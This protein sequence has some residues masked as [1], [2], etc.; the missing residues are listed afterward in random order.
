MDKK[1]KSWEW[2]ESNF[3]L[4]KWKCTV[5]CWKKKNLWRNNV[6]RNQVSLCSYY[7]YR[8]GGGGGGHHLKWNS[9]SSPRNFF[10]LLAPLWVECSHCVKRSCGFHETHACLPPHSFS[11]KLSA[12]PSSPEICVSHWFLTINL[13]VMCALNCLSRQVL[14]LGCVDSLCWR[15][16]CFLG[17]TWNIIFFFKFDNIL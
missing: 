13:A 16:C 11:M 6:I 7:W 12:K 17:P 5:I 8:D 3:L 14:L 4:L 10:T 15:N 2:N 1:E 9:F